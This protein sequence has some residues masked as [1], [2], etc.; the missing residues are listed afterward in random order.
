M[1]WFEFYRQWLRT[2]FWHPLGVAITVA[3]VLAV[4][5]AAITRYFPSVTE[6]VGQLVWQAPLGI[7]VVLLP[8]RLLLAPF[9]ISR[10]LWDSRQALEQRSIHAVDISKGLPKLAFVQQA[11]NDIVNHFCDAASGSGKTQ[12]PR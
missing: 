10:D 11:L 6:T 9:W 3:G 4:V 7:F 2:A 8:I 1:P 5:G 12:C